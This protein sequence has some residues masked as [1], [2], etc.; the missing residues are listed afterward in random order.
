MESL[1][2]LFKKSDVFKEEF[3]K[4][5]PANPFNKVNILSYVSICTGIVLTE[6]RKKY[7]DNYLRFINPVFIV[8]SEIFPASD[9]PGDPTIHRL[10]RPF[11]DLVQTKTL[12]PMSKPIIDNLLSG[13]CLFYGDTFNEHSFKLFKTFDLDEITEEVAIHANEIHGIYHAEGLKE[14]KVNT[15]QPYNNFWAFAAQLGMNTEEDKTRLLKSLILFKSIA[16][17]YDKSLVFSF[18]NKF[19]QTHSFFDCLLFFIS[20]KPFDEDTLLD[21]A[22]ITEAI[23]LPIANFDYSKS[24][25]ISVQ[26]MAKRNSLKTMLISSFKRV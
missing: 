14:L 23:S 11:F 13:V 9:L 16:K 26:T 20:E 22:H 12:V 24:K 3:D 4:I 8:D 2:N 15:D 21:F 18:V 17:V 5:F 1:S 7:P 10:T 6:A 25:G 19:N